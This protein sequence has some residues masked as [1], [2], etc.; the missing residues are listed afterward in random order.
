MSPKPEP[1]YPNSGWTHTPSLEP[2]LLQPH[3]L[4]L[5][6]NNGHPSPH[7]RPSLGQKNAKIVHHVFR[8]P[9]TTAMAPPSRR[10]N[11][12][13]RSRAGC[14]TCKVRKKKCD[15]VRPTCGDCA[16]LGHA[17]VWSKL[18]KEPKGSAKRDL[19]PEVEAVKRARPDH[20]HNLLF[21]D[22]ARRSASP[23]LSHSAALLQW[24]MDLSMSTGLTPPGTGLTPPG[25]V[26]QT[27]EPFELTQVPYLDL[28]LLALMALLEGTFA[29]DGLVSN[30]ASNVASSVAP[31][32]AP[33][34]PPG[35]AS[36]FIAPHRL[37][38]AQHEEHEEQ[39]P[40]YTLPISHLEL[41]QQLDLAGNQLYQY[42]CDRIVH[43][44]LIVLPLQNLY[45]KTFVPM[46]HADKG[47]LFLLLAW[48]AYHMGGHYYELQGKRYAQLAVQHM[49]H[50][51]ALIDEEVRRKR[52]RTQVYDLETGEVLRQEADPAPVA[53]SLL[54]K[55]D[56]LTKLAGLLVLTGAEIC[57]GD[58]SRWAVYL[59]WAAKLI[60]SQLGGVKNLRGNKDE[61]WLLANF[62]YHDV[63]A[64]ST[65]ERG[66]YF[67]MEEYHRIMADGAVA[68]NIRLD[69]LHGI[70]Q[71]LFRYVG[72]INTMA[73]RIR[74][75]LRRTTNSVGDDFWGVS[76]GEV[77]P[78]LRPMDTDALSEYG[79]ALG[80]GRG[81]DH[82]SRPGSVPDSRPPPADWTPDEDLI[83]GV[84]NTPEST[85]LFSATDFHRGTKADD[86]HSQLC[87]WCGLCL[88]AQSLRPHVL[89]SIVEAAHGMLADIDAAKP[90]PR[91]LKMLQDDEL[92]W[93]VGLFE[94]YQITAKLYLRQMVLRVA[95]LLLGTQLLLYDSLKCLLILIRLPVESSLCFPLF[96][97]GIN[98]V[99]KRDRALV[100]GWFDESY[101]RLRAGNIHRLLVI[102]EKVWRKNPEGDVVVDWFVI[103]KS[104]GW[105][106]SFA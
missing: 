14:D 45:L 18:S 42:F 54:S 106:L 26:R 8:L 75:C 99:T 53:A 97:A 15:E 58:V 1:T 13:R 67:P 23:M 73:L 88:P 93:Q 36:S 60:R 31:S 24:F 96:I 11:G 21:E 76:P 100:K 62:L 82:G 2:H 72:E 5:N 10:V 27:H 32:V 81:S 80:T 37:H 104:M 61:Y 52:T 35:A 19:E 63:T 74:Q 44:I 64:L 66:T 101:R 51:P 50:D 34:V 57:H 89:R 25:T 9:L 87:P 49:G 29:A 79:E 68:L 84:P 94:L 102:M 39:L 40:L 69:P 22:H 91:T 77:S 83:P 78:T 30:V 59:D 56:S 70:C 103:V 28:G 33:S 20:H 95:P 85:G 7:L 86:A 16:R 92:D 65:T 4:A 43:H 38:E 90:D 48:S 105:D 98:C 12:T 17:C 6:A 41:V 3:L 47:V 46:A 71:E 55:R